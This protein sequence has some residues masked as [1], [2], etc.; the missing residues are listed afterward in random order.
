M[1]DISDYFRS[2]KPL[3]DLME[4]V[5]HGLDNRRTRNNETNDTSSRSIL[6]INVYTKSKNKS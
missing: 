4:L 5:R 2:K 6:V 1:V 3:V